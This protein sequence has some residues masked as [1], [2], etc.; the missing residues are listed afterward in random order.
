MSYMPLNPYER[1]EITGMTDEERE[2]ERFEA[3]Q[4]RWE[5]YPDYEIDAI[6]EE[7]EEIFDGDI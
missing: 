3:E 1:Y 7:L 5:D 2:A 4:R 6:I